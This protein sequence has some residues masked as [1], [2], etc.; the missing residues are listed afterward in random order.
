MKD[1]IIV[2]GPGHYGAPFRK[3]GNVTHK[4][5]KLI[6][7]PDRIKLMVF[8]GGEDVHPTLYGGED[9]IGCCFT[10]IKRD[11]L[12]KSIFEFCKDHNIKMT[13]ICRGFQFLN[14]MAGGFMYQH[15]ERHSLFR[16]HDCY[17]PH[18]NK[19]MR[20]TSTHHQLVGLP[21]SAFPIAWSYPKRSDFYVGPDGDFVDPEKE[22]EYEIEAA[23]FPEINAMGVQYHPEVMKSKYDGRKH[24]EAMIRDFVDMN[25]E[26]FVE[27]YSGRTD[28]VRE[29]AREDGR[30]ARRASGN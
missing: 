23:I 28:Y 9:Q 24:Y 29:R 16:M 26:K 8:S 20:V 13:G 2:A 15:L 10:N 25:M 27:K 14:V 22:P 3:I 18:T 1:L 6:S 12:E 19:V 17:F 30:K 4:L 7:N 21:D 11:V 5:K